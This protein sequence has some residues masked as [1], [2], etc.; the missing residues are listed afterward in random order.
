MNDS[1]EKAVKEVNA[2]TVRPDNAELTELYGLYKQVTVGDVDIECPGVFDFAG[3]A[4]WKAWN[5][6]KGVSKEDAAAAYIDLA[7][8]LKAKYEK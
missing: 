2:L 3:R 4:K 8:K 6:K 7:E 5:A 1:F